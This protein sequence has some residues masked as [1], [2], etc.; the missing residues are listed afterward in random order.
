MHAG[1]SPVKIGSVSGWAFHNCN[2]P[3]GPFATFKVKSLPYSIAADSTTNGS[4][5]TDLIIRG[6][7]FLIVWSGCEF[8]LTGSAAGYYRNSKHALTMTPKL[9]IK[10]LNNAQL[11]VKNVNGCA[12]L[13]SNGDHF[14]IKATYPFSIPVKI[15]ST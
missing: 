9:P 7:N 6:I 14:T 15:N 3:T 8:T 10:P 13:P 11:T 4:G 5:E 1:D 2:G 12:G